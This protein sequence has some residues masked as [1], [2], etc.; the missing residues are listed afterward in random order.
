MA[1]HGTHVGLLRGAV[2]ISPAAGGAYNRPQV[3]ITSDRA[4]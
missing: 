4:V 3:A 2:A 1:Q